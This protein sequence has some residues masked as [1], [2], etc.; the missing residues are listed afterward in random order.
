MN[1][2]VMHKEREVL[3][4]DK[5]INFFNDEIKIIGFMQANNTG[6]D[7]S[8]I[9]KNKNNKNRKTKEVLNLIL[10]NKSFLENWIDNSK[11]TNYPPDFYSEK[12]KLMMDVMRFNDFETLEK[13]KIINPQLQHESSAFK[14]LKRSGFLDMFPNVEEFINVNSGVSS[15]YENY[16]NSFRRVVEKHDNNYYQYKKNHPNYKLIYLILDESEYIYYENYDESMKGLNLIN[17]D[18]RMHYHYYDYN[19]LKTINS[20]KADYVIWFAPYKKNPNWGDFIEEVAIFDVKNMDLSKAIYYK[21]L[22]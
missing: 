4:M 17:E 9:Y 18:V 12:F 20:C 15:S 22:K 3:Y 14:E 2:Y 19:F 7:Y 13:G 8:F 5:Y 11:N 16:F 1:Y 10:D 6:A 21:D